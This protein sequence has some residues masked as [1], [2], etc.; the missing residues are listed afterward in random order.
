MSCNSNSARVFLNQDVAVS[1]PQP[2]PID[3]I[4]GM[5]AVPWGGSPPR[6]VQVAS[7]HGAID[8]YLMPLLCR[9]RQEQRCNPPFS[10]RLIQI[11]TRRWGLH[12]RQRHGANML[13]STCLSILSSEFREIAPHGE[14]GRVTRASD[15][16]SC[17]RSEGA[18]PFKPGHSSL[19]GRRWN[20]IRAERT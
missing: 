3:D 6:A 10:P 18:E 15:Q 12:E 13:A 11:N 17:V 2:Q 9:N 20:W 1:S 16:S 14:L 7:R 4:A 5:R 19:Q 8:R